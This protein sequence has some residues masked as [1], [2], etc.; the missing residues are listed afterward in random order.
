VRGGWTRD[1]W[2]EGLSWLVIL[3][4]ARKRV[5]NGIAGFVLGDPHVTPR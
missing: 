2:K 4:V 5:N 1:V 3:E